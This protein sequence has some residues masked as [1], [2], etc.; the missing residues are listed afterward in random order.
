MNGTNL[1]ETEYSLDCEV[2]EAKR[3][4][5]CLIG[6]FVSSRITVI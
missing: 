5:H 4:I 6:L 1:A 3:A 2:R